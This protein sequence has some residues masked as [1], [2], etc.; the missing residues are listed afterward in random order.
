V[1]PASG[2]ISLRHGKKGAKITQ[3]A[4]VSGAPDSAAAHNGK[5]QA[6]LHGGVVNG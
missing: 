4:Q 1:F 2:K 6:Q 3:S 5:E